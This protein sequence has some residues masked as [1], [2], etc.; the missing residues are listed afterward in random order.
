MHDVR[1]EIFFFVF[2]EYILERQ[3]V[4]KSFTGKCGYA[5]SMRQKKWL[6]HVSCVCVTRKGE[7]EEKKRASNKCT[8]IHGKRRREKKEEA[9][10]RIRNEQVEEKC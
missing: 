1:F 8:Y 4:Y 7:E 3:I 5:Q 6:R 10:V 2:I 9:N